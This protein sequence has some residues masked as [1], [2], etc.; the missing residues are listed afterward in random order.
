MPSY[1]GDQLILTPLATPEAPSL[2]VH[3]TAGETTYGYKVVAK[4]GALHTAASDEETTNSGNATLSPTNHIRITPPYVAGALT[5]DIY[6]TTGGSSQ[7]KIGTLTASN[8]GTTQRAFFVDLGQVAQAGDP[9]TDN[10]TGALYLG[11]DRLSAGGSGVQVAQTVFTHAD[12]LAIP[13]TLSPLELV[14]SPGAGKLLVPLLAFGCLNAVSGSYYD[15]GAGA[16]ALAYGGDVQATT[17]VP[18][19]DHFNTSG[20]PFLGPL[21]PS[22]TPLNGEQWSDMRDQPLTLKDVGQSLAYG[23]GNENNTL[24]VTVLYMVVTL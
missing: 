13:T 10:T 19:A 24:T 7:G 9:P 8:R 2:L 23:G 12:I 11:E 14:A 6:R 5:Y 16:W 22:A 1:L 15:P 3:G 4:K 21:L 18:L 17:A 20:L